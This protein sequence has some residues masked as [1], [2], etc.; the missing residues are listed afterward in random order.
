[1]NIYK[2][3]KEIEKYK[4]YVFV[5]SKLNQLINYRLGFLL[6]SRPVMV[7]IETVNMCNNNCIICSYGKY[8]NFKK[9]TMSLSL[10]KKIIDDY[11]KMGG[12]KISL[13]PHPGEVFLDKFILDRLK[14]TN[15]YHNITG[16]SITTN[17]VLSLRYSEDDLVTI[18]NS[19]ERVHIS[20]YGIDQEEYLSMT[21]KDEYLLMI[22]SIKRM[23]SL[24]DDKSKIL[25]GFRFLKKRSIDDMNEWILNNFGEKIAYGYTHEYFKWS[26]VI[27]ISKSLPFDAKWLTS[28]KNYTQCLRPL[29]S[30]I[31]YADGD[32]DFCICTDTCNSKE[33]HIG[34]LR[35]NSLVA[36]YNSDKVAKLWDF[37]NNIPEFCKKCAFH[38][39]IEMLE[40]LKWF[41]KDPIS[42]IGG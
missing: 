19:L 27:D 34:N 39:P 33:L 10:F 35:N 42:F 6:N 38:L 21:S 24:I 9:R 32:V 16:V 3:H 29:I 15:H 26:E 17:A 37:R 23:L 13:T 31:I 7:N 5:P 1:M 25:F 4:K 12:G 2:R 40:E 36:I 8:S 14:I 41:F 28:Q 20:I 18:L 30:P 11:S 22:E